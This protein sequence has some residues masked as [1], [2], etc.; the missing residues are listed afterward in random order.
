MVHLILS[1]VQ[2]SDFDTL[3]LV[4]FAAFVP[5]GGH[6]AMFGLD[7]SANREHAKSVFLKDM[8]SDASDCWLKIVDADANDRIV[9]GGNWKIYPTHV[10]ADVDRKVAEVKAMMAKDA[11]WEDA[12]QKEDAIILTKEFLGRRYK[13]MRE[14]HVCEYCPLYIG[15]LRPP[16][17]GTCCRMKS[18]IMP[19]AVQ[20]ML[21]SSLP[22]SIRLAA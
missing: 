10:K 4:E 8:Q 6:N 16:G 7:T 17:R 18:S 21:L 2:A 11:R 22:A 20:Q 12:K 1:R 13:R 19:S 15:W 3:V 5:D 9:C 14:P